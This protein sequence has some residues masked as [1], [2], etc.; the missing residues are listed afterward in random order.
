M[1]AVIGAQRLDPVA[2]AL[3]LRADRARLFEL[4]PGGVRVLPRGRA[5]QRI[6][7]DVHRHAPMA[8]AQ[9]GSWR[10]TPSNVLRAIVNQY[11]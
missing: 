8:I 2:L 6:A 10:S 9:L 5:D 11:E 3:G 7:E 4:R 1:V